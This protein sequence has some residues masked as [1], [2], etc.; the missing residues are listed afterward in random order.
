MLSG[1]VL[2]AVDPLVL[3]GGKERLC[4]CIVIA[5]TSPADRLAQVVFLQ[6]PGELTRSVITA[7][8]GVK[9]RP[10]GERI[11]AGSHL[12]GLSISRVL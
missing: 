7:A 3:Q 6:R 2:G 5:D 4:H 10:G 9:N 12:D 1:Q 11:M 8:I